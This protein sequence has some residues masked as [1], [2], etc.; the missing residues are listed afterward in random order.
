MIENIIREVKAE[1]QSDGTTAEDV[2]SGPEADRSGTKSKVGK[3]T[4]S[5]EKVII[6]EVN[7]P[8]ERAIVYAWKSGLQSEPGQ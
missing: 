3:A 6:L 8:R 7:G 1:I 5:S 2:G 4:G